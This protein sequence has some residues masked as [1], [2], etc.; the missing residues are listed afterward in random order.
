MAGGRWLA[1]SAGQC[2]GMLDVLGFATRDPWDPLSEASSIQ[3]AYSMCILS[4]G[5]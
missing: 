3:V 2:S 1:Y 5:R 4:I